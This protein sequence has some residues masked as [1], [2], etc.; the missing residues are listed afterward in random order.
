MAFA[1]VGGGLIKSSIHFWG[2]V[3]QFLFQA[4]SSLARLLLSAPFLRGQMHAPGVY[5]G[6]GHSCYKRKGGTAERC[7]LVL[8]P[9]TKTSFA[10]AQ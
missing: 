10:L 7:E 8:A 4:Q 2:P 6:L 9:I 5:N 1:D 3:S